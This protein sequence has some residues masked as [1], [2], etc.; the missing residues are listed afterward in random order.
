LHERQDAVNLRLVKST[1]VDEKKAKVKVVKLRAKQAAITEL[2]ASAWTVFQTNVLY[3]VPA[4]FLGFYALRGAP[5][6]MYPL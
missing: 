1:G 4:L 2:E 5:L 6:L 3:L